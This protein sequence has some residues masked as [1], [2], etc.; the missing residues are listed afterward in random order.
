MD[1]HRLVF[2][3][4]TSFGLPDSCFAI[5]T[6]SSYFYTQLY[7]QNGSQGA[8][9][10]LTSDANGRATW[11][12]SVVY[13]VRDSISSTQILNSYTSPDTII[14]GAGAGTTINVI[15]VRYKYVYSTAPYTI[16]IICGLSQSGQLF[17]TESTNLL[18]LTTNANAKSAVATSQSTITFSNAPILYTSVSGDPTGGGG[19][20]IVYIDYTIQQD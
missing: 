16:P 7:Y 6:D 2:G 3:N 1:L 5:K 11:Q 12:G 14:M 17:E 4:L 18:A 19:Y 20:L 13:H 8:G 15:S 10:V 9:K